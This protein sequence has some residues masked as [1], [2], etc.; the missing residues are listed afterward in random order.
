MT[1]QFKASLSNSQKIKITATYHHNGSW[2]KANWA[3]NTYAWSCC[4][5]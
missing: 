2:T 4:M 3:E 1:K 5:N